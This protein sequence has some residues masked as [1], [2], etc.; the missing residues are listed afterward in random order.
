M[1][2]MDDYSRTEERV[3][4][5]RRRWPRDLAMG[6]AGAV[7]VLVVVGAVWA[8]GDNEPDTVAPGSPSYSCEQFP[9]EEECAHR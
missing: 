2:L 4:L 8:T 3:S 1:T 6:A 9:L 5:Q 7:G